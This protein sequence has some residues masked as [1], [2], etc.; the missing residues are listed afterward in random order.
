MIPF[1][2]FIVIAL[3][4]YLV[5]ASL[6]NKFEQYSREPIPSGMSGRDI[7]LK[8]LRDNGIYDVQV[9]STNGFLTD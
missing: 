5:Q 4:S 6:K 1:V 8:M 2:I 7:A 3:V 9:R